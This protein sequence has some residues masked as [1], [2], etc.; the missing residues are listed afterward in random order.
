MIR[1]PFSRGARR[2]PLLRLSFGLEVSRLAQYMFCDCQ[3]AE[4]LPAAHVEESICKKCFATWGVFG[5]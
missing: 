4:K 3:I 1:S 2:A 5:S